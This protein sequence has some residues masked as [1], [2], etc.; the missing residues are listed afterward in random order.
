MFFKVLLAALEMLVM[1][2]MLLLEMLALEMLALEML[3]L[4]MLLLEM[5]L[6]MLTMVLGEGAELRRPVTRVVRI[7]LLC[8]ARLGRLVASSVSGGGWSPPRGRLTQTRSAPVRLLG[9]PWTMLWRSWGW[10]MGATPTTPR[11]SLIHI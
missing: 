9:L 3:Q 6:E 7:L 5:Q 1:L 8:V 2:E 4:E 10:Y 11:L